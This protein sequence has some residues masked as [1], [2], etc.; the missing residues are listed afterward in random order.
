MSNDTKVKKLLYNE[1]QFSAALNTLKIAIT[2]RKFLLKLS[3]QDGSSI[4]NIGML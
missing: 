4:L 2:E 1:K 3:H